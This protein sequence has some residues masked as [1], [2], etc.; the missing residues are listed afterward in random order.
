LDNLT[1]KFF[2]VCNLEDIKKLYEVALFM[3]AIRKL[4]E[5]S[6]KNK[7]SGVNHKHESTKS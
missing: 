5:A 4:V 6:E 2:T 7:K 1:L 3:V